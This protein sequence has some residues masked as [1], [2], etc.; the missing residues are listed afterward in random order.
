MEIIQSQTGEIFKISDNWEKQS[1]KLIEKYSVLSEADLQYEAG[2][3]NE[4]LTRVE[5]K[6]NKKRD[7]VINI[8]N[9]S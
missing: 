4:L 8:I 3:E 5:T 6:L 7:D 1:K 9:K 2:K